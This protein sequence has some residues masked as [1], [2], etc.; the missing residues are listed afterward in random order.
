MKNGGIPGSAGVFI[1]RG[2]NGVVMAPLT[3]LGVIKGKGGYRFDYD[4]SNKTLPH[5]LAHQ[6]TDVEY[7]T[8]GAR[9]WFSEGLAEYIAVTPYRSGKFMVK[10]NLSEIKDYV[11]AY[12]EKGRGGRALGERFDAPDLR[13]YMLQPYESFTQNGNFN[14]GLGLLLTYYFFHMEDDRSN[15]IAFLKALKEGKRG[16]EAVDALLNG[17]SYD[18]LEQDVSKAWRSRG[19]RIS[20]R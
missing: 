20:F 5:E 4:G 11:T 7:F 19:V 17:R 15:I 18:Q 12:G 1:S 14:Y 16:Q 6:L 9:G 8:P 2:G 3:S 13:E 10:S